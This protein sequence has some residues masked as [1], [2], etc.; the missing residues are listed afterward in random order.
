MHCMDTS[1]VPAAV[2]REVGTRLGSGNVAHC[3]PALAQVPAGHFGMAV[4]TI[5]GAAASIGDAALPF[6]I[7]SISEVFSHTLALQAKG[8]AVGG[9]VG[10][11]PSGNP[12][13]AL[14]QLEREEERPRNPFINAGAIRIADLLCSACADPRRALQDLGLKVC[15]EA[16][17]FD[18]E[19]ADSE[20]A[21]GFRNRALV[22][23]MKSFGELDN[24]VDQ[25][26]DLSL[27]QCAIALSCEQLAQALG[28]LANAGVAPGTAQAILTP[29]LARR[30]SALMLTG[31]TCDAA[32][33]FAVRIG[34]PC[35]SGVGAGIVPIV[36]SRMALCV[37]SPGLDE[38]GNS[39]VRQRRPESFVVHTGLSVF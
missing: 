20:R 11:E 4:R 2:S 33:E 35:K 31:A 26:L 32:G 12:F 15:G 37:W 39:A 7:Q 19:V 18:A 36:S 34:L 23:F 30:V 21:T 6:S 28:C 1:S 38:T 16:F 27:H 14:I 8:P 10:R 24:D 9:S 17:Q 3:I 22:N 13:N 5:E 25:V 29:R